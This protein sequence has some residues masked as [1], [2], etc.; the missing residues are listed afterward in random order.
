V[1]S[2]SNPGRSDRDSPAIGQAGPEMSSSAPTRAAR[3]TSA[4]P[5]S[6]G[7]RV[8]GR[9]SSRC[10]AHCT[11]CQRRRLPAATATA[12]AARATPRTCRAPG[13]PNSGTSRPCR[14]PRR[15]P[16]L[17]GRPRPVAAS[18]RSRFSDVR[19]SVHGQLR[20]AGRRRPLAVRHRLNRG[21]DRR[22]RRPRPP[23]PPRPRANDTRG[24]ERPGKVSRS[25][26]LP[27]RPP[28]VRRRPIRSVGDRKDGDRSSGHRQ[29]V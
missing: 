10:M 20:C 29:A 23:R 25:P 15:G 5:S 28:P 22:D 13:K 1:R 9:S 6:I 17:G 4:T 16:R 14:G 3:T 2:A 19:K 18:P 27:V 21:G 8:G 11:R 12:S 26:R 7:I 24:A